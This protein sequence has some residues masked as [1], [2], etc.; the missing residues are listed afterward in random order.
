MNRHQD[1][2]DL[3]DQ[4]FSLGIIYRISGALDVP[5]VVDPVR[6]MRATP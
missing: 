1:G 3:S 4:Q 5:G 6:M 2:R